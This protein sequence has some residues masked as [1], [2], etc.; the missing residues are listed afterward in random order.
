MASSRPTPFVIDSDEDWGTFLAPPQSLSSRPTSTS[1][2]ATGEFNAFSFVGSAI[3]RGGSKRLLWVFQEE[4]HPCLGK[5]GSSN[6]KMCIRSRVEGFNHCGTARHSEKHQVDRDVALIHVTDQQVFTSPVWPLTEV[7]AE[8]KNKILLIQ[9]SAEDWEKDF[10]T[11]EL[12]EDPEWLVQIKGQEDADAPSTA[13][14]QESV[15]LLSPVAARSKQGCFEIVPTFSFESTSFD[16]VE[17]EEGIL[18]EDTQVRLVKVE[19]KLHQLKAKLGRPFLDIDASYAVMVSDLQKLHDPV[20]SL[21]VMIGPF[22]TVVKSPN[23][24]MSRIIQSSMD[25][26]QELDKFNLW[27]SADLIKLSEEVE[28]QKRSL[29]TLQEEVAEVQD[30]PSQFDQWMHASNRTFE[31]FNKRFATIRTV[32][33]RIPPDFNYNKENETPGGNMKQ[34][35][36][37]AVA[38]QLYRRVLDLEEKIKIPES[39]VVGAGVQLGGLVFQS[40]EDFNAWVK[41]KVPK[42]RFGLFV[43]GYS[44]LEFFSLSGHIDTESDAAAFSH[45]QKTG[46]S[47]C[48]EAQLAISFKNLFP[49]VFGKGG[50]PS[51]DDS[52]CLPDL[53][54]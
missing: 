11:L 52:E 34:S 6:N 49:V 9:Q 32:M 50:S 23:A 2:A 20:K 39:R 27:V 16:D 3:S 35:E 18:Q 48:I 14:E 8:Q 37:P 54:W 31:S 19:S 44:F 40:F 15:Q 7:S 22:S 26:I 4:K 51:M 47:T 41:L 12:G 17:T 1:S 25:K 45:S 28:S 24:T 10:K 43:D 42:E 21:S 13:A 29:N 33:S 30:L 53:Y 36:V 46:F 5:V 38:D